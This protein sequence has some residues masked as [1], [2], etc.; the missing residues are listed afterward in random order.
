[1]TVDRFDAKGYTQVTRIFQMNA[2]I[3]NRYRGYALA[4]LSY[5]QVQRMAFR[6]GMASPSVGDMPWHIPTAE[7][8]HE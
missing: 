5:I 4:W 1:M 7:N 8:T 2:G 3:A 6:A